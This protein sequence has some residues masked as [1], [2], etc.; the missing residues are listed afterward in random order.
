MI[1]LTV[2]IREIVRG[3]G[4]NNALISGKIIET[5]IPNIANVIVCYKGT[6]TPRDALPGLQQWTRQYKKSS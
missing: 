2:A 4:I 5:D 3:G 6:G 1:L